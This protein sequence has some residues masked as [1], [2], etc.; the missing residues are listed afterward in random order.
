MSSNLKVFGDGP[1]TASDGTVFSCYTVEWKGEEP[2]ASIELG[3][4]TYLLM[5][6]PDGTH[7]DREVPR[8][9]DS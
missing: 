3:E 6:N 1:R 9:K 2:P 4:A 7:F 5:T 8:G